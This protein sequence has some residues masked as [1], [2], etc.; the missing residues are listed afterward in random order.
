MGL[1]RESTSG[2]VRKGAGM[3]VS[4][5]R[6]HKATA[7]HVTVM[8]TPERRSQQCEGLA[9]KHVE[10]G[11]VGLGAG[12]WALDG[13]LDPTPTVVRTAVQPIKMSTL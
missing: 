7:E 1:R 11:R 3:V 5:G 2:E 13:G 9:K 8:T 10:E 12:G 4:T 6:D